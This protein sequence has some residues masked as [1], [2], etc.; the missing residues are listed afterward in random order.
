VETQRF[1]RLKELFDRALELPPEQRE[2]FVATS[3]GD[4]EAMRGELV[5]LLDAQG[6]AGS[7][8]ERPAPVPPSLAG[9]NGPALPERIG[10]YR[11]LRTLG[12]GGMGVVYLAVRSDGAFTKKVAL[13]LIKEGLHDGEVL[14][15]FRAERQV[16]ATFDHPNIARILDG[17]DTQGGAP[18]YVMEFVE[19]EPI[20]AYCTRRNLDLDSR[21][22]LLQ[23]L[24]SAVHYLHWKQVLHRDLKPSNIM[25]TSEGSV[26]LIDFGIAKVLGFGALEL[27]VAGQSPST[28]A[29]ASPEQL[30]GRPLKPSADVYS[31]GVILYLLVCGSRPDTLKLKPPSQALAAEHTALRRR[32]S[33][34]LDQIVMKSLQVDPDKRYQTPAELAEDLG[35]FLENRTVAARP[36]GAPFKAARFVTRNRMAVLIALCVVVLASVGS[37]FAFQA[38][39]QKREIGDKESQI[40][41]L[42]VQ[43][44]R[45]APTP[46]G[47]GEVDSLLADIKQLRTSLESPM[48]QAANMTPIQLDLRKAVLVRSAAYLKSLRPVAEQSPKVAREVGY[49]YVALGDAQQSPKQPQISDRS[50]AVNSFTEAARSLALAASRQPDEEVRTRLVDVERRLNSLESRVPPE[51]EAILRPPAPVEAAAESSASLP[52]EV[53]RVKQAPEVPVAAP[54]AVSAPPPISTSTPKDPAAARAREEAVE[55]LGI[56]EAQVAS[57][58]QAFEK[59]KSDLAARGLAPRP[60]V[61]AD[62]NRMKI[63]L[64]QV[65]G[66][67]ARGEFGAARD[68]LTVIEALS[69]RVSREYGH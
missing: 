12:Q 41:K 4:D 8:I 19:G 6:Q 33:G 55:R 59:M 62:M 30:A 3:C 24:C 49:T 61:V 44:N 27:T 13:K 20:D 57:T 26:K 45:P 31:L 21:R 54:P 65:R 14:E 69:A 58:E 11:I 37:W 17:G 18:Y 15:R 9:A 64:G 32:L 60:G 48:I 67:I 23:Q 1:L 38:F 52:R 2:L 16:L 56:A 25:V 50:S 22:R 36:V 34:D 68:S 51:A 42:L 63:L 39:R 47:P 40:Q 29:Y 46:S 53:K 35:R 28:P 10:V 7:F 43:L 5:A 66:D